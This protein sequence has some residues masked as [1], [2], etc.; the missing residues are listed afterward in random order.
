[1]KKIVAVIPARYKSTRFEGKPLALIMGK[2]MIKH[3]YEGVIKS[4]MLSD[5]IIATEDRRIYDACREFGAN[6]VM[7]KDTHQTGTDRIIEVISNIDTDIV[8]NIQGDEPLVN[9]EI[10]EA[11]IKP[12]TDKPFTE[13]DN[14][15]YTTVKTPIYTYEEFIDP[16]TVKVITDKNNFGIY[17]SRSPIPYDREKASNLKNFKGV[18]GYKHL[19]FYGYTK[20]FLLKFGKM[21]ISYLEKKEMLEQLR[22]IENGYGIKVETVNIST[23]PVD[24]PGDIKKVENF[25]L[26]SYNY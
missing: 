21:D 20:E 26:K 3:V 4:E 1:M 15:S 2:P 12:F 22:A 17:F 24:V 14:I 10:I 7:T 6:A 9:S 11:L 25:I 16:N 19:G 18:F 13:D 23:I 8:L 5:V